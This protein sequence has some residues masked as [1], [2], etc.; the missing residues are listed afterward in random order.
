MAFLFDYYPHTKTK[1][2]F[3]AAAVF[4]EGTSYHLLA[5]R[6]LTWL[7]AWSVEVVVK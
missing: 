2:M 1:V 3:R 6:L 4:S 5:H 7:M